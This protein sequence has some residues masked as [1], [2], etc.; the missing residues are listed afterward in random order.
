MLKRWV[1]VEDSTGRV[2]SF[3]SGP[4]GVMELQT[5]E[6]GYTIHSVTKEAPPDD[7]YWSGGELL[8]RADSTLEDS[9]ELKADGVTELVLP[10][11]E[12]TIAFFSSSVMDPV[13]VVVGPEAELAI[14]VDM[15][16]QYVLVVDPFPYK[17]KTVIINGIP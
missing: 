1:C 12:G 14:T 4:G 6:E 16:V 11:P 3:G 9:Y 17:P 5:P 15:A 7:Y 13:Q 10:V 8:E 2:N